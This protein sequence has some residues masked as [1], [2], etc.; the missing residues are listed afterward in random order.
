[1]KN[2]NIQFR[3]IQFLNGISYLYNSQ[4]EA[5]K[6]TICSKLNIDETKENHDEIEKGIKLYFKILYLNR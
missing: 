4:M 3:T 2:T 1:M 6:S 5:V